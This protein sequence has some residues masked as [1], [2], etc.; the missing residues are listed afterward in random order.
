VLLKTYIQAP[1]IVSAFHAVDS[2]EL[3]PG[4]WL[5]VVGAGGL[6]QL[7]I[8]YAKAMSLNVVAVDIN[9]ETL[10][11]GKSQGADATFNSKRSKT[12]QKE[13]STLPQSSATPKLHIPMPPN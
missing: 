12:L 5:G 10:E 3:S 13:V 11:V 2:C 4:Q 1:L 6:G 8:Q 7:A 9:D